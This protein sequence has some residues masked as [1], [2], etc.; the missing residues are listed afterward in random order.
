MKTFYLPDEKIPRIVYITLLFIAGA[1]I[2]ILIMGTIFGLVLS[3]EIGPILRFGD[4]VTTER[5][6][7]SSSEDIRIFS[8]LGR[9]RIPLGNSSVMVISISFP[10]PADD[11]A[12]SEELAAR[13]NDFKTMAIS[14]FSSLPEE[15]LIQINEDAAKNE[16]LRQ[17]NNSLRLGR[18]ET[19]YFSEMNIIDSG[20]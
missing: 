11:I 1:L 8:G 5:S 3:R 17:Y 19:L 15:A 4:Q 7:I 12:F 10:Y 2:V 13:I 14:Y 9:L 18:I 16:I 6:L 20:F